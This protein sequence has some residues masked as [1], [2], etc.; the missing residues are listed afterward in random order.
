M[1]ELSVRISGDKRKLEYLLTVFTLFVGLAVSG[2]T[3]FYQ[4]YLPEDYGG[5]TQNFAIVE[6]HD[7]LIY[8]G[9]TE[10]VLVYDGHVWRLIETQALVR[11]L[12]VGEDGVI[13]VGAVN[14]FGRLVPDEKG[15]LSYQSLRERSGSGSAVFRDVWRTLVNGKDVWFSSKERLFRLRDGKVTSYDP[16][17]SF[18]FAF[19]C[20]NEIIVQETDAG[21]RRFSEGNWSVIP[22]TPEAGLPVIY[23]ILPHAEDGLILC[24]RAEGLLVYAPKESRIVPEATERF[25]AVRELLTKALPYNAQILPNGEILIYTLFG[26]LIHLSP[27]GELLRQYDKTDGLVSDCVYQA[28]LDRNGHLWMATDYGISAIPYNPG[29]R[30]FTE[31]DGINGAIYAVENHA[32]DIYVGT[33][34]RS[35]K[36][37]PVGEVTTVAGTYRENWFL[38]STDAGLLHAHHPK[39]FLQTTG[40]SAQS[41]LSDETVIGVGLSEFP[42][43]PDLM[44]GSTHNG[45]NILA[46]QAGR[47]V[48]RNRLTD[49][50]EPIFA[51]NTDAK[52]NLWVRSAPNNLQQIRFSADLYQIESVRQHDIFEG[53]TEIT[54]PIPYRLRD[55]RVVFGSD[56]GVFYY[57]ADQDT[58]LRFP[59]MEGLRGNVSPVYEDE[60]GNLW[61]EESKNGTHVKGVFYREHNG[62]R[63][64]STLLRRFANVE[65]YKG[66][67][68]LMTETDDGRIVLGTTRGLVIQEPGGRKT[69]GENYA[70]RIN[71]VYVNDTLHHANALVRNGMEQPLSYEENNIKLEY[72]ALFYEADDRNRYS[73]RLVGENDKWSAY[74]P[75]NTLQYSNLPAGEYVFEVKARNLYLEESKVARY[76]FRILPP[77]Y[78]TWWAFMGYAMLFSLFIL[79]A[80]LTTRRITAR[81]LLQEN[82]DLERKVNQRTVELRQEKDRSEDLSRN[83]LRVFTIIG[84][85]LRRPVLAFQ[86]ITG[87]V[88]FLLR[89]KDFD[90][91]EKLG[92]NIEEE[93]RSLYQLTDN[94]L[95]WAIT[96]QG[97]KPYHPALLS[98]RE[99]T[100]EALIGVRKLIGEK[101]LELILD[102]SADDQLYADR[103]AMVTVFRNL[104]S[105]AAKFTPVGGQIRLSSR[106]EGNVAIV[107]VHNSGPGIQEDLLDTIFDPGVRERNPAVHD[108]SGSGIGLHICRELMAINHG[109]ISVENEVTGGVTFTLTVPGKAPTAA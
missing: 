69:S 7:G 91:L 94:L 13:Y 32:G 53:E 76:P 6:G 50:T 74:Q 48:L 55:G 3:L 36:V 95:N 56:Q 73:H 44:I 10:G 72:S 52:G 65:M 8:A 16:D 106:R 27:D 26:G 21:L 59:P 51:A 98:P 1:N 54:T 34:E 37:S 62:W 88:N 49:F 75:E 5:A 25:S 71:R 66:P 107:R 46:L 103:P 78:A 99:V 20:R 102:L 100:E 18:G 93:A 33:N 39:G 15:R 83:L 61:Y 90:R 38:K 84:H 58:F 9:N 2:Q 57:S 109:T 17:I 19:R 67:T 81:R 35:Y 70:V 108:V 23:A 64:D 68:N 22:G 82:E 105:N 42:G 4:N 11:S 63:H 80:V 85:D 86:G 45:F 31:N 14:D 43:A 41:L 77:W 28:S 92:D 89:K 24:T 12:A 60:A 79:T 29:Y 101:E 30:Y 96:Q 97:T 104:L 87:K 47:W 40:S